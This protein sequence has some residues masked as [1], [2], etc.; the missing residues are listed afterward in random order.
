MRVSPWKMDENTMTFSTEI[1]FDHCRKRHPVSF[2]LADKTLNDLDRDEISN[3]MGQ[4]IKDAQL[5]H[6]M[7]CRKQWTSQGS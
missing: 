1:L 6:D 7:I 2:R 3:L 5:E 4:Q